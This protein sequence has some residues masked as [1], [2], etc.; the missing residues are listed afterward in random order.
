[1]ASNTEP[2][3]P[4]IA[5]SEDAVIS[6]LAA[7]NTTTNTPLPQPP[8]PSDVP[9]SEEFENDL[10]KLILR[11]EEAAP[12]SAVDHAADINFPI[13]LYSPARTA[14]GGGVLHAELPV[15]LTHLG[16]WWTGGPGPGT[17][18]GAA[19]DP[20]SDQSSEEIEA[21]RAFVNDFIQTH[22]PRLNSRTSTATVDAKITEEVER[23]INE[24]KDRMRKREE[25]VK[26]NEKVKKELE[27][28]R[29]QRETEK[30]VW[31]R[32]RGSRGGG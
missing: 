24:V 16:G 20:P 32:M 30:K 27:M 10:M 13:P 3:T 7:E 29:L 8:D 4:P 21:Q 6:G 14:S 11:G 1:M 15:P 25:A 28:L 31:E 9:Y 18:A 26:N 12:K 22:L 19:T 2:L 17:S 23:L 5:S